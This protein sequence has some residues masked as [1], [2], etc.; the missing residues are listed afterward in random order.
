MPFNRVTD[1]KSMVLWLLILQEDEE[2]N[3]AA[4]NLEHVDPN[5]AVKIRA[6]PTYY[7]G[8]ML[9]PIPDAGFCLGHVDMAW[10]AVFLY[11]LGSIVYVIDS[12]YIWLLTDPEYSDDGA[13]PAIYLNTLAAL[14]FVINA[15]VCFVDWWLQFKQL[16]A[17]NLLFDESLTG[18]VHISDVP[19]KM[20]VYYF[21]NNLFFLGAAVVYMIQAIWM[22][23]AA[24][25]L[26]DC[27]VNL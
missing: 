10:W 16:S 4:M 24:T 26:L 11:L 13:N 12:Y 19:H 1:M 9:L 8:F 5:N 20:S 17:M 25:D 22:E 2:A 6:V 14:L 3:K 21:Y 27:N 7:P 23:N 15:I 18:G